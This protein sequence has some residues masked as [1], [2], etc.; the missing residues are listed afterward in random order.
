MNEKL[1]GKPEARRASS[2]IRKILSSMEA[3][4]SSDLFL[5]EG[6]KPATRINGSVK[7][8]NAPTITRQDFDDF[9]EIAILPSTRE[10]FERSGDLDVGY[11]LAEGRRFRFNFSRQQGHLAAVARALPSGAIDLLNL[12]LPESVAD[13]AD[14]PRGLVLIAGATGS[15]KSTSMAGLIN[16]MNQTRRLHIVTIEDPIEFLH[17]D[18]KSRDGRHDSDAGLDPGRSIASGHWAH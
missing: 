3:W 14:L 16:R 4:G 2:V 12:G 17:T 5:T 6:K 8:V 1:D 10:A 15:G 7:P 11:S 13:L 18:V 9:F